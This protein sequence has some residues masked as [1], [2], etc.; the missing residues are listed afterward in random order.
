MIK[1]ASAS[2]IEEEAGRA[3]LSTSCALLHA[4]S[5]PLARHALLDAATSLLPPLLQLTHSPLR[6][7]ALLEGW[8]ALLDHLWGQGEEVTVQRCL[9]TLAHALSSYDYPTRHVLL[10]CLRAAIQLRPGLAPPLFRFFGPPTLLLLL[11]PLREPGCTDAL[12]GGTELYLGEAIKLLFQAFATLPSEP[13]ERLAS[14]QGQHL[15]VLLPALMH[16]LSHTVNA[17]DAACIQLLTTLVSQ[18][19]LSIAR[20]A[21]QAFKEQ[22]RRVLLATVSMHHFPRRL[23]GRVSIVVCV[24]NRCKHCPRQH[25]RSWSRCCGR[26]LPQQREAVPRPS[27]CASICPSIRSNEP[28]RGG[29]LH[30]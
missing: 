14:L 17:L 25:G 11:T 4:C 22:V 2:G 27:R 30:F 24:S 13:P 15:A 29:S 26:N 8:W 23:T 18:A 3:L 9:A 6:L 21:P 5:T 12:P 16:F 7:R 19:L 20:N 28:Y 10:S 1:A